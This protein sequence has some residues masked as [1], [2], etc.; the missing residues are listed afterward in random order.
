MCVCVFK[1]TEAGNMKR[2]NEEDR[3]IPTLIANIKKSRR[4]ISLMLNVNNLCRHVAELLSITQKEC[5]L[6]FCHFDR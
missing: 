4:V 1:E 5:F 2:K 6:V 3:K